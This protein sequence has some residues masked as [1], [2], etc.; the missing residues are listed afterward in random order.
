MGAPNLTDPSVSV[1]AQPPP[2]PAGRVVD[3]ARD[4][5]TAWQDGQ[6]AALDDLV[7]L[8]TPMLWHLARSYRL[9]QFAAEDAVQTTWLAL[10]SRAH[11]IQD[12]QAL[13]RW[14][15][16]TVQRE[17]ARMARREQRV[18]PT[19]DTAIDLRLPTQ[20][21][22]EDQVIA[23]QGEDVLWAHLRE[24]SPR[25]QQLLRVLAFCDRPDYRALSAELGMP[26]G[27]IGPT[28]GRCLAKLK[29]VCLADPEW[30]LR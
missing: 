24:L 6:A 14:L 21:A 10:V 9:D 2:R 23:R 19:E 12:P 29:S 18:E 5:F 7:R 4:L 13:V 8:L 20:P 16:V 26:V 22:P 17:A 11:T 27:S 25:C 28:R 15:S 30:S 1:P 3:R